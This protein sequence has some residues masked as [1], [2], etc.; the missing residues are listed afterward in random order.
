MALMKPISKLTLRDMIRKPNVYGGLAEG[1]TQLPLPDCMR[2]AYKKLP[3]PLTLEDFTDKICYGQ[4]IFL[5]QQ[6]P[7]DYGIIL[8]VIDGFYY[9]LFTNKIWDEK[10]ALLFGKI[11][12]TC[13]AF[14]LY[15]IAMHF[16]TLIEEMLEKE[17]KLLH[18]EPSRNEKAAGIDR[19]NVF[20][21]LTAV[22]FLRKEMNKNEEQVM[23][24]PYNECLVRFMLM[25]ET[26]K[27]QEKLMKIM[28]DETESK[29]KKK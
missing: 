9:S 8:R 27:F 5:T 10:K 15:P 2:I 7:N 16:V 18:R 25:H 19:L 11:V 21:E 17:Y 1:L 29:F 4:R 13:K 28:R 12:I 14:E 6:E 20:S 3:I 23:L 22:D 24:T 26:N